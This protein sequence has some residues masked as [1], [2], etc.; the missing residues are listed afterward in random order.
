[1][2][3]PDSITLPKSRKQHAA[4]LDSDTSDNP[5]IHKYHLSDSCRIR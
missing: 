2:S 1:M 3:G 4:L 5:L